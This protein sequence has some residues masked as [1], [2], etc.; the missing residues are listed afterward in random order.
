M[1]QRLVG[2]KFGLLLVPRH[3]FVERQ[4]VVT[5]PVKCLS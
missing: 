2:T 5:L 1:E 4:T 3:Q